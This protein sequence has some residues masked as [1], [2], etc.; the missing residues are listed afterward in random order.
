MTP[1]SRFIM[2]EMM[3]V[4][5]LGPGAIRVPPPLPVDYGI[6]A[7]YKTERDLV[8][9]SLFNSKERAMEDLRESSKRPA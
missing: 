9:M 7:K 8:M 1:N 3:L 6:K 5:T 2:G 4:N